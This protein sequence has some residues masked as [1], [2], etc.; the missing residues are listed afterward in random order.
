[1]SRGQAPLSGNQEDYVQLRRQVG[2]LTLD[3]IFSG[4]TN[5]KVVDVL[6]AY[7]VS[8]S[9]RFAATSLL[10]N[11]THVLSE[12]DIE[13]PRFFG[14]AGSELST[15]EKRWADARKK[16]KGRYQ[17]NLAKFALLLQAKVDKEQTLASDLDEA[18]RAHIIRSNPMM[19]PQLPAPTPAPDGAVVGQQPAIAS[20]TVLPPADNDDDLPTLPGRGRGRGRTGR[21]RA[22]PKAAGGRGRGG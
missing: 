16:A 9:N 2:R 6:N 10:Q 22:A 17:S 14:F 18:R 5:E 11:V 15:L 7:T 8:S 20:K 1:M 12:K 13:N 21:G 19:P 3:V 4:K